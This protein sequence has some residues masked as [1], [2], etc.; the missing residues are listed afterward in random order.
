MSG[1]GGQR[2]R[3][4]RALREIAAKARPLGPGIVFT[5]ELW[6]REFKDRLR[7]GRST[8][9]LDGEPHA[10]GDFI[11]EVQAYAACEL[12]VEFDE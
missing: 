5:A 9:E 10:W 7:D 8:K 3:Y 6:H 1:A 12:L 4:W 2:R 11:D